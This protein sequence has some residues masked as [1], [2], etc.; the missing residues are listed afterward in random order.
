MPPAQLKIY[1][2]DAA[3]QPSPA[4]WTKSDALLQDVPLM[5]LGWGASIGAVV[6]A[7]AGL[8]PAPGHHGY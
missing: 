7:S 1:G 5:F 6:G 4:P 2:A 8:L 3:E